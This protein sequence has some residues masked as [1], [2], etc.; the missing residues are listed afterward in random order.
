M[1]VFTQCIDCLEGPLRW[2]DLLRMVIFVDSDGSHYLN[3]KFSEKEQCDD[4]EP[5][6][7]CASPQ[8]AIELF[9]QTIVEDDCGNCAINFIANICDAC[10]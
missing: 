8:T 4:Y 1:S 2:E 7:D 5:A 10:D 3:L 6:V 9:S